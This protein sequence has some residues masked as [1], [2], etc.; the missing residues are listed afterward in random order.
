MDQQA[1]QNLQ[2]FVNEIINRRS[3]L[4]CANTGKQL[5]DSE[6]I[7]KV[8]YS[9]LNVFEERCIKTNRRKAIWTYDRK[10]GKAALNRL[11]TSKTANDSFTRKR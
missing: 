4:V 6:I 3:R 11:F 7:E 1:K 10:A 9:Q 5:T 8:E 2:K